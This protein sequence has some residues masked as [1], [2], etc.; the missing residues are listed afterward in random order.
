MI[1]DD[2]QAVINW[3]LNFFDPLAFKI[4][5]ISV[6]FTF[7]RY[8]LNDRRW[9]RKKTFIP[10]CLFVY[11][12]VYIAVPILEDFNVSPKYYLII[13]AAI[14]WAGFA[15]IVSFTTAIINQLIDVYLTSKI[16]A[17]TKLN[18]PSR[19]LEQEKNTQLTSTT[20]N[21]NKPK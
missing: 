15:K 9:V 18:P 10:E 6:V 4:A 13:G 17:P 14:G 5:F 2:L 7:L 1:I 11:S 21:D 12:S 20:D 8:I 3:L 16:G 19:Q